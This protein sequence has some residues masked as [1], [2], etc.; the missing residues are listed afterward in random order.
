V[1]F[2]A[3][4]DSAA[5]AL[6][7]IRADFTELV[8]IMAAHPQG[9]WTAAE[10]AQLAQKHGL[11]EDLKTGSERSRLTRMGLIAGRYVNEKFS[12]ADK[13]VWFHRDGGRKGAVYKVAVQPNVPNV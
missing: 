12:F 6:D 3:N 7:E 13:D 5:A 2:L 9:T 11:L 10:L 1:D 8:A 4:A